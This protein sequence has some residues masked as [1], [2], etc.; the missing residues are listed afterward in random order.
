RGQPGSPGWKQ[1]WAFSC[2]RE[3]A[4]PMPTRHPLAI[5]RCC[6]SLPARLRA[7]YPSFSYSLW[8]TC[9]NAHDFSW[10]ELKNDFQ[11]E[12]ANRP[13]NELIAVPK[14]LVP[15]NC[16][17]SEK[18][19]NRFFKGD[20]MGTERGCDIYAAQPKPYSNLNGM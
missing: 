2:E 3:S 18:A 15:P 11:F 4:V 12:A 13:A 8:P 1:I 7:S 6:R 16:V 19:F 10:L 14:L 17:V 5:Q 9:N 20:V